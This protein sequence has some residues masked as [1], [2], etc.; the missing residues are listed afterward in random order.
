MIRL[1][2]A[3]GLPAGVEPT[4]QRLHPRV[5]P[6]DVSRVAAS[7]PH[8]SG[9]ERPDHAV[10]ARGTEAFASRRTIELG[11]R[12]ARGSKRAVAGERLPRRRR[13]CLLSSTAGNAVRSEQ[14]VPRLHA[15]R[16]ETGEDRTTV[17]SV[18]RPTRH[19]ADSRGGGREPLGVRSAPRRPLAKGEKRLFPELAR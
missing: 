2:K 8:V 12:T 13:A 17:A 5:L 11:P 3:E 15:S 7:V 6:F 1:G 9:W 14:A 16:A 4:I 10:L 18:A 19:G